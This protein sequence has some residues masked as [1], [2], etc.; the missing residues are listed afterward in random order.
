VL[1]TADGG[2]QWCDVTGQRLATELKLIAQSWFESAGGAS[3][4]VAFP[5]PW[6]AWITVGNTAKD[7]VQVW[8]TSDGGGKW[9][10]TTLYPAVRGGLGY[11]Y[12]SAVGNHDAWAFCQTQGLAG[13][14]FN[15]LWRTSLTDPTWT[16]VWHGR[17]G[18]RFFNGRNGIDTG[19]TLVSNA[20][21]LSHN[22]DAGTSWGSGQI[23]IPSG[24][25]YASAASLTIVNS[26]VAV[27]PVLLAPANATKSGAVELKF[28]RTTNDGVSWQKLPKSPVHT[29]NT[30]GAIVQTW[31]NLLQGWVMI[32]PR[33]YGT[34]NGG[35][36]W[37]SEPLP[38]ET[39]ISLQR[40]SK[41]DGFL[42]QRSGNSSQL[43]RTADGG[44]EWIAVV[45]TNHS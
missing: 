6:T 20:V 25:F 22:N 4:I 12:L 23:S 18:V 7:Q 41:Q 21:P 35:D 32:G 24:P 39:P 45:S 13:S 1:K 26:K 17:T 27:V 42:L 30:I 36:S 29:M 5:N 33:L 3:N 16:A 34:K 2:Q 15:T 14:T 37:D 10:E 40:L 19:A 38:S 44:D 28:Y 9:K 31:A 11:T 8:H 43:Y